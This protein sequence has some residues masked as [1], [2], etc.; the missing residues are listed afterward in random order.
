MNSQKPQG[1]DEAEVKTL[2][3]LVPSHGWLR[4][5]ERLLLTFK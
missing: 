5:H 1:Q 4:K 2:F 3:L